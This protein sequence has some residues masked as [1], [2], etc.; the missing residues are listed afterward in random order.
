LKKFQFTGKTL[1]FAVNKFIV[2]EVNIFQE[3][4]EKAFSEKE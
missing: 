2:L 4:D 3:R 1:F